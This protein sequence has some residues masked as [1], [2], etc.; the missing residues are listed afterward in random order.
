MQNWNNLS[1]NNVRTEQAQ[2]AVGY[3]IWANV[4]TGNRLVGLKI[5]NSQLDATMRDVF[6]NNVQNVTIE[7]TEF[8][9]T[10]ATIALDMSRSNDA[11]RL[12]NDHFETA[13][14]IATP[15]VRR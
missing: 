6:I 10:G 12:I 2:A 5:N 1:F 9:C 3:S 7:N 4:N 13:C 15:A 8:G 14:T 11:V